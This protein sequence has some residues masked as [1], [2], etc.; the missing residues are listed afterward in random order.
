MFKKRFFIVKGILIL[1]ILWFIL[2]YNLN[3]PRI[4][5]IHSYST[6]LSSVRAFDKGFSSTLN[7]DRNPSLL[8]YYM[9]TL[10][11]Q[12]ERYKVATG[13][14]AVNIIEDF[15]PEIIV[16]V[17]EEAQEYVARNYKNLSGVKIVYAKIKKPD[18][19]E[20]DQTTNVSGVQEQFPLRE[21]IN[22]LADLRPKKQLG[23]A[24]I[25]DQTTLMT[26]DDDFLLNH[27]WAPHQLKN[28][29]MVSN[30]EEWK[31]A[32]QKLN[33]FKDIDFILL[34]NY[35]NLKI[36][37]DDPRIMPF[38]DVISWTIENSAI[39]IIG[40]YVTNSRD[41]IPLS[42]STSSLTEGQSTAKLVLEI[43]DESKI[44]TKTMKTN[45]FLVSL[46]TQYS[47]YDDLKIPELYKSFAIASGLYYEGNKKN[48]KYKL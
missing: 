1:V 48:G 43:I 22:V 9:N 27:N 6:Q 18:L 8:H 25:G 17:G 21:V 14:S 37:F 42:V 46:N 38:K 20:Y 2:S 11:R 5:V 40:L 31:K 24:S 30:F 29:I 3:R 34:S 19:Y 36:S 15:K 12:S 45:H 41:G 44:K 39:P 33:S 4:M 7:H 16:T 47:M 28:S 32:I 26:V 10:N 23:L 35:R 13:K